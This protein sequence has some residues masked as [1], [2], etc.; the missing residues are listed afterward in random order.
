MTNRR[1]W[2]Q[3]LGAGLLAQATLAGQSAFPSPD[4]ANLHDLM[5]WIGEENPP[6]LSFLDDR[7]K[8]VEAWKQEARPAFKEL[9]RYDPEPSPLSA[10]IESREERDG[11]RLETL[12]ISATEQYDIPGWLLIPDGAQGPLPGVIAIHDHGG[13]YV[14]G[15]EKI[16]SHPDELPASTERREQYYERPFAEALARRGF[17]VLVIDGFYFGQRRLR[18]ETMDAD[19][20]PPNVRELLRELD[21]LEPHTA[22]WVRTVDRICSISETLTAKTIFAA[23]ATWPG[24]LVWDDMRSVDYLASRPEVDAERIGCVGLS[25]GG[26]RTAYLAAADPRIKVSCVVGWMTQFRDQLRNHLRHHT[27]M[28]YVPGM[29]GRLDLP[30][31]AAMT[32]PGALMVQQCELDRLYPM[33]GMRGSVDRLKKI[34]AKAGVPERFRGEFY[35]VPHSFNVPMQESAFDW[36]EEWI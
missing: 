35:D 34:F 1:E 33:E 13:R 9:L 21:E 15:Q 6:R 11:F 5:R 3:G 20:A 17:V 32:V 22:S 4:L 25:I 31:A 14:W 26:L 30:D 2:L 19:T 10:K 23:G 29:A 27:W 7:W 24:M 16:L 18:P 36:I 28:V 12:K 8:S